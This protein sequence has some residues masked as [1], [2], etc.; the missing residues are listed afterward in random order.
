MELSK[1]KSRIVNDCQL[2]TNCYGKDHKD[3]FGSGLSH[4]RS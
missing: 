4:A 1:Y 3:C 2:S